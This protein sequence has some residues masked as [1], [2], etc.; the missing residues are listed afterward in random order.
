MEKKTRPAVTHHSCKWRLRVQIQP[1]KEY[2]RESISNRAQTNSNKTQVLWQ[3]SRTFSL[4]NNESVHSQ[5]HLEN[6]IKPRGNA[7]MM[8]R[9]EEHWYFWYLM[10]LNSVYWCETGWLLV[11]SMRRSVGFVRHIC[12]F[13]VFEGGSGVGWCLEWFNRIDV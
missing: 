10:V 2:I 11:N 4:T 6:V 9:E 8:E 5:V 13:A 12:C 3:I 1:I 7:G